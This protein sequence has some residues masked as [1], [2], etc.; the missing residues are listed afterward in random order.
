MRLGI[1]MVQEAS[2]TG[3]LIQLCH[4]DIKLSDTGKLQMSQDQLQSVV[5][6]CPIFQAMRTCQLKPSG[7]ACTELRKT[8]LCRETDPSMTSSKR[9]QQV[10]ILWIY[11]FNG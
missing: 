1:A 11:V 10:D 9:Q 8:D 5:N 3:A 2:S 7:S 4:F 6:T